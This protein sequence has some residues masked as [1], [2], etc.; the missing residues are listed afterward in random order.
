MVARTNVTDEELQNFATAVGLNRVAAGRCARFFLS[1][2]YNETVIT[3]A[4]GEAPKIVAEIEHLEGG[5]TSRTKPADAFFKKP[6]LLGLKKKHYFVGGRA[7]IANNIFRGAGKKKVEFR[8][9]AQ[10]HNNPSTADPLAFKKIGDDTLKLYWDRSEAGELTGHWIV[11][12]EHDGKN[13]YLC[14]ATHDEGDDVIA[15][16]IKTG[17]CS[18]FPFLQFC[19]Q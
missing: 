8:R 14:L 9:I 13:Y 6:A 4:R 17:C 5:R 3:P 10:R 11:F 19:L 16:R 2:I 1:Q 15:E 7:A 18:E 12:A